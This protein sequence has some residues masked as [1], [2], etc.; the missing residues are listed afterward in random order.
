MRRGGLVAYTEDLLREQV[1]RG[2]DVS[3]LF[4]GH[5]L[6]FVRRPRLVRRRREDIALLEIVSSPLFDHGRQPALELDEPR[7]EALVARAIERTRPDVM[8]V[9]ELAGL[10][11]SILDLARERGVPTV[12]TLQ[13]YFALCPTFKLLD[14]EGQTC[15]RRDVGAACVAT[16]AADPRP[17]G[18]VIEASV[19]HLASKLDRFERDPSFRRR[20]LRIAEKVGARAAR[21]AR[22]APADAAAYQRRREV[23]V[24]R[25]NRVD[26]L[27]AMSERV[28]ELHRLL[29]VDA[30]RLRT[31]QLTLAHIERLTPRRPSGER[32]VTFATLGGLESE[33][34]GGRL[35]IEAVRLLEQRVPP[36][37]F[38]VLAFGHVYPAF[39][40]DAARHP[41]IEL[42]RPFGPD[43]LDAILDQVDVGLMPSLWE[44]AYGYAGMEMIAKGIPV[45]GN[46]VGGIVDY[47]RDGE[48]GW[49]NRS[50][51]APELAG[52]MA[53]AI[54][55]PEEIVALNERILAQR[56][57]L[58]L[59]MARHADAMDALYRE[60]LA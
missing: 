28:A 4:A 50:R 32:P 22:P 42:R 3:Y 57:T 52:L 11:S 6:P 46:A 23:N 17:S 26:R 39:T 29:G 10:P 56:D 7:V 34:K 55:R 38:R 58:V 12:L 59:P 19:Y 30:E 41:A 8:H 54:E 33:A 44:E 47:V 40:G 16:V 20:A 51:S 1:K 14:A 15:I 25:L 48:T 49:V 18:L 13:D 45:I 2:H 43:H 53:E 27:V 35:L 31:M 60:L 37:S 36:G 24:E 21:G 5:Y 9:H